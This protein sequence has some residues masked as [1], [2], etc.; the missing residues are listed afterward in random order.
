MLSLVHIHVCCHWVLIWLGGIWRGGRW[1][2]AGGQKNF[3][4]GK[5]GRALLWFGLGRRCRR[6]ASAPCAAR[7]VFLIVFRCITNILFYFAHRGP[8]RINYYKSLPD[9]ARCSVA[10]FN[11]RLSLQGFCTELQKHKN[12]PRN[13]IF[14][15]KI[16]PTFS[17]S[18]GQIDN[19]YVSIWFQTWIE[20]GGPLTTLPVE[21]QNG[22][23]LQRQRSCQ[24]LI[25]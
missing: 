12:F 1:G 24:N 19:S 25:W 7:L 22:A 16:F 5:H 20:N 10:R 6:W 23:Q 13:L 14:R 17:G 21:C 4:G 8:R 15:V 11:L 9:R 18:F 2:G 3:F